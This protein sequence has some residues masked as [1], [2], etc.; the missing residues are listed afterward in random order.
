[1]PGK[2]SDEAR[3]FLNDILN[4]ATVQA[5]LSKVAAKAIS[6]YSAAALGATPA[7]SSG[8]PPVRDAFFEQW[9]QTPESILGVEEGDPME[10]IHRI[11]K[12]KARAYA[13]DQ[14]KL[15]RLNSAY[16]ALKVKSAKQ[17][18]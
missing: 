9:G 10:L 13:Q 5:A 7:Q 14:A 16:N 17:A 12:T 8:K 4:D 18:P 1:M 2:K 6:R 15:T 11:H 3:S